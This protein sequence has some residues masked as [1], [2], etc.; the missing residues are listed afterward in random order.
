MVRELDDASSLLTTFT[1]ILCQV[2]RMSR[3]HIVQWAVSIGVA[4][5]NAVFTTLVGLAKRFEAYTEASFSAILTDTLY[6]TTESYRQQRQTN[7]ITLPLAHA[8]GVK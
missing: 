8:R 2:V 6:F 3:E 5:Q 4:K 1:Y 7:P